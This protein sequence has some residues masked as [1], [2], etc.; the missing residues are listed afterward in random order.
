MFS[1]KIPAKLEPKMFSNSSYCRIFN[2]PTKRSTPSA[3]IAISLKGIQTQ[4][5]APKQ[6]KSQV[7]PYRNNRTKEFPRQNRKNTIQIKSLPRAASTETTKTNEFP[8]QTR[9]IR[10]SKMYS[11][12]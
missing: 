5:F 4:I 8:P 3:F 2:P 7:N 9:K 10:P 12:D 6:I 11:T 1:H